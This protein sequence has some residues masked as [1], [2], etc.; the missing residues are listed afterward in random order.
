MCVCWQATLPA[1]ALRNL[2]V[3]YYTYEGRH[4]HAWDHLRHIVS[5]PGSLQTN[6]VAVPGAATDLPQQQQ[7]Q[8]QLEPVHDL[9]GVPQL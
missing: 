6:A 5:A 1:S 9:T 7:Q 2:W 3:N 4:Q 8:Q